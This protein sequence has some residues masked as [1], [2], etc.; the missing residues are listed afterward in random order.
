MNPTPH[1]NRAR[2]KRSC[3]E[4]AS[5]MRPCNGFTRV[6]ASFLLRI[7]QATLAAIRSEVRSHPSKGKTLL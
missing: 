3:L 1:L 6:G 7:E 2:V 5:L 4:I